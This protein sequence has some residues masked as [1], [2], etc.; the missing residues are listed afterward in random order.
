MQ[1]AFFSKNKKS[2]QNPNPN[3]KTKQQ[4]PEPS[5]GPFKCGLVCLWSW[6]ASLHFPG[7][8][9]LIFSCI[10][11]FFPFKHLLPFPIIQ[12]NFLKSLLNLL[13]YCLCFV[14]WF[15][16][17]E[18]CGILGPELGIEPTLPALEGELL[19][20]GLQEKTLPECP[21][22]LP[23]AH[24]SPWREQH[25]EN[26]S[27]ILKHSTELCLVISFLFKNIF[28]ARYLHYNI[29]L[30]SAIHQHE[31]ATDIHMSPPP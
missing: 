22:H 1:R 21:L 24:S 7:V 15:F 13:Q 17:W 11:Y 16:G 20:P 26:A 8:G 2:K 9:F 12:N 29:V 5:R 30:V 4:S 3:Q 19:A 23:P 6:L 14:F 25:C 31:S 18:A 28:I 10:L 27:W